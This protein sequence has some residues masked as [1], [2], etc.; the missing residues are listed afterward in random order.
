MKK[1]IFK[2]FFVHACIPILRGCIQIFFP[3]CFSKEFF[4]ILFLVAENQSVYQ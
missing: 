1:M 2:F 4:V 3:F